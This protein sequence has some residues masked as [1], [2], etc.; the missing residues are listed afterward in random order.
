MADD[1]ECSY[2]TS[3][4]HMSTDAGT[5]IIISYPH[6]AESLRC[7]L[8]EFAKVHDSSS[9]FATHELDGDIM[10]LR[11]LLIDLCFYLSQLLGSRLRI[12]DVV[13]LGFILLH[14][15]IP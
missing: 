7:I 4:F 9:L 14:V 6:Y 2:L 10:I 1:L 8:R 15:G 12:E 11:D 3:I 13:A 5:C